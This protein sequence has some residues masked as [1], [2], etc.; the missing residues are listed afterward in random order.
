MQVQRLLGEDLAQKSF[1]SS[2][3]RRHGTLRLQTM[4][5]ATHNRMPM[6]MQVATYNRMNMKTG[7]RTMGDGAHTQRL[8]SQVR[9]LCA[10]TSS[11][12]TVIEDV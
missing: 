1:P 2:S 7:G 11:S 3:G 6:T 10:T 9:N 12:L 8:Q 4:Q 5:A